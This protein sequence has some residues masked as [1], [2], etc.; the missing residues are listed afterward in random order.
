M[1]ARQLTPKQQRFVDEYLIDLNATAAYKRAGY[2]A[3]TDNVAASSAS[4]LLRNPKVAAAIAAGKAARAQRT[5]VTADAVVQELARLAFSRMRTFV[6]WGPDG[7][8]L[9]AS[10]TLS[11]D[12]DA[13]V[14]EVSQTTTQSGGTV[15]FKLHKKEQALRMLGQHT[16]LFKERESLEVLL[17]C[18]PAEL[19]AAVRQELARL[20]SGGGGA[21]GGGQQP[22]APVPG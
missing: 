8:T 10:D 3:R 15:R 12:A 20:L 13:C 14:A 9:N 7:V 6:R 22:V 18:L 4:E 17:G 11:E 21:P 19:A 2:Q 1:A 5:A 16:G